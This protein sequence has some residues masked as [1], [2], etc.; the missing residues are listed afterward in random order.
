MCNRCDSARRRQNKLI[1][2]LRRQLA[3]SDQLAERFGVSSRT[4]YRDI[5]ILRKRG[6][7]ID[8]AAGVGY[9]LRTES[10]RA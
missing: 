5:T 10:K 1:A 2:A 3:T 8:G 6:V 9:M 4:I 7:R